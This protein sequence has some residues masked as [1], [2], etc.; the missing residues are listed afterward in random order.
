ML[1]TRRLARNTYR[2][3][4]QLKKHVLQCRNLTTLDVGD[5]HKI[6]SAEIRKLLRQKG[7]AVH[8]GCTSLSTKCALCVSEN[9]T[10]EG[11]IFV[12]KTTGKQNL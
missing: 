11:K 7:F 1:Q 10:D 6:S 12:N 4:I 9:K 8:D 3:F 5:I 2:Q